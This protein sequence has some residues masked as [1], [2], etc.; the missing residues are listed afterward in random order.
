MV[1]MMGFEAIPRFRENGFAIR[2]VLFAQRE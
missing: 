1:P 2:S